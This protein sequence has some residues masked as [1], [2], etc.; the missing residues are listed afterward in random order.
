MWPAAANAAGRAASGS[1]CSRYSWHMACSLCAV[2]STGMNEHR[3]ISRQ[4]TPD[5]LLLGSCAVYTRQ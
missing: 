4:L 2:C 1:C 5:L 3:I